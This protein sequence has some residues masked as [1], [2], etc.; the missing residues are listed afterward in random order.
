MADSTSSSYTL[1]QEAISSPGSASLVIRVKP[2]TGIISLDGTAVGS[3]SWTG[4]VA[5]G[6]HR[7]SAES[8]DYFP[9]G[10]LIVCAENTKYTIDITLKPHTGFLSVQLDPHDAMVYVDGVK[11][12]GKLIELPIG[13]RDV[14]IKKFGYK[15]Y[16]STIAIFRDRTSSL[17]AQLQTA[18]FEAKR[19]RISPVVFDTKNSGLYNRVSINFSV[20]GPG[21]ARI[22]VRDSSG[23]ELY[24]ADLPEFQTW[25]QR[26]VWKGTDAQGKALPDGTYSIIIAI[27][28]TQDGSTILTKEGSAVSLQDIGLSAQ[29]FSELV[30]VVLESQVKIDSSR[31]IVPVGN[32][33]GRSGL[34]FMWDP[35][36]RETLPGSVEVSY[37]TT[38]KASLS[39]G[40]RIGQ[41]T[42]FA[43]EGVAL[44]SKAGF[45]ASFIQGLGKPSSIAIAL[46]G[47]FAWASDPIFAYPDS[48]SEA[49]VSIPLALSMLGIRIGLSPALVYQFSDSSF[50]GRLGA[51]AWYETR[52][53]MFGA[54]A[55]QNID[56][57]GFMNT[58]NPLLLAGEARFLFNNLPFT[59]LAKV[60]AAMN[61]AVTDIGAS[62]GLGLAW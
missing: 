59:V 10:F 45:S 22:M 61:P 21:R 36:V 14:V 7:I 55:Q 16:R 46:A 30:P 56:E 18:P 33:S 43:F 52:S 24:V 12:S 39:L 57:N 5:P 53:F 6:Q 31:K 23:T 50:F 47:R 28:P 60:E 26:Q 2:S 25:T 41:T 17:T 29:Q 19:F 27:W 32:S 11:Y 20:S 13:N 37:G 54:S 62:L 9:I 34:A 42:A 4:T 15:D 3:S 58:Q 38:N 35:K 40:L 49:E 48:G 44:S 8:L 51:G 1:A